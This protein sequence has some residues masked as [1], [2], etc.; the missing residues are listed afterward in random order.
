MVVQVQ[1]FVQRALGRAPSFVPADLREPPELSG[2]LP[3]VG[4]TVEFVRSAI[5]LLTRAQRELGEVAALR[6]AGRRMVAVFGPEAHEA[7]FRAPDR[8]MNPQEAYKIMTPVFGEGMVYD[9]PTE[10]MNE[11]LKM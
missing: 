9:A 5:A 11:Q 8:V 10:I 6:V 3:V 1:S 4:H 2:A 7:V